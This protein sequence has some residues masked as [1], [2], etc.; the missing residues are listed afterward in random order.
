MCGGWKWRLNIVV[1]AVEIA[2]E[3]SLSGTSSM[4]LP[5]VSLGVTG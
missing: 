5:T 1:M 4:G 3:K 2:E